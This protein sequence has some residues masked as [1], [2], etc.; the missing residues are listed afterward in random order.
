MTLSSIN[1]RGSPEEFLNILFVG[2]SITYGIGAGE[3][4]SFVYKLEKNLPREISNVEWGIYNEAVIGSD[5]SDWTAWTD[6]KVLAHK[7]NIVVIM[8]G[9]NDCSPPSNST[10]HVP[11][12]NYE[13]N[14][15]SM[16]NAISAF[17]NGSDY[18]DGKPV[19]ILMVPPPIDN[20]KVDETI[21]DNNNLILYGQ[22][23][24]NLANEFKIPFVDNYDNLLDQGWEYYSSKR[25]G[26]GIHIN[27]EGH[28]VI[29]DK[30]MQKIIDIVGQNG[31]V[32]GKS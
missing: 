2:D 17:N 27:D 10:Q 16:I 9:T 20:T 7:P 21:R 22:T 15:R 1:S 8:L 24:R 25:S 23:V 12:A 3:G 28:L 11:M 29:Y 4:K 14:L 19:I 6:L 13:R 26:D 30:L 31:S 32:T 18:N 5:T